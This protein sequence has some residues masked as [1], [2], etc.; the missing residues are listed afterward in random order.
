MIEKIEPKLRSFKKDRRGFMKKA[1]LSLLAPVLPFSAESNVPGKERKKKKTDFAL[2]RRQ[3]DAIDD[4]YEI[5]SNYRRMDQVNTVFNRGFWDE[6][7]KPVLMSLVSKKMGMA[8]NPLKN[9]PGWSPVDLALASAATKATSVT[10]GLR[11]IGAT[12]LGILNSWETHTKEVNPSKH[13]FKSLAEAS[14]YVKRAAR[15]LGASDVG[16]APYDERWTYSKW[17]DGTASILSGGEIKHVEGKFPFKVKSVIAMVHEMDYDAMK[18][19]GAINEAAVQKEYASMAEVGFK[20]A[21]FLNELGYRCIPSGN[22]LG[23]SVPVAIQA[24]L[25]EISR[26]GTLIHEKYG[27]R[28]RLSK[29]YTDLELQPDKPI[30]FG[31]Q[32]FCRKCKKCAIACPSQSISLETEPTKAPNTGTISSH[33]GVKKWYQNGE[34]CFQ[35]WERQGLGCGI[36]V[37]VCPYNK[38]DNWVHDISKAVVSIPVGRD[39]ARQ[40]DDAFGYG[41]IKP[42]NVEEF[43]N[44]DD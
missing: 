40:L 8:P 11:A 17:Y 31:V 29:I 27:S 16:I 34:T 21:T 3:Y 32:E 13:K 37:A 23:L 19:P 30:T 33:P 26:M 22:D 1:S 39:V 15:F 41:D 9:K 10:V 36:C 14:K 12:D 38:K 42:G 4:I 6:K 20:V 28:I 24:G 44:K 35:Y 2:F 25:G 7:V 43:W 18:C 5:E